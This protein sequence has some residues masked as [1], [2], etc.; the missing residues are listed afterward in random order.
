[1]NVGNKNTA[2]VIPPRPRTKA[3]HVCLYI[4]HH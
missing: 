4:K 1:M 2:D 3:L